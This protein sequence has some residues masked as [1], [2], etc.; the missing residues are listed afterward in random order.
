LQQFHHDEGLIAAFIQLVNRADAGMVERGGSACFAPKA[1]Q[2][3]R[4]LTRR[5]RQQLDG[6]RPSQLLVFGLIDHAHAAPAQA[7]HDPVVAQQRTGGQFLHPTIIR[8]LTERGKR[9]THAGRTTRRYQGKADRFA[10]K[11]L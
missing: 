11:M 10:G 8:R 5:F 9:E 6:N 4:V 7:T 2:R 1:F 3:S